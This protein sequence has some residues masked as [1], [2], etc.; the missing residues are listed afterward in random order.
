M[1]EVNHRTFDSWL[2]A[3]GRA[4]NQRYQRPIGGLHITGHH[5]QAVGAGTSNIALLQTQASVRRKICGSL[6][7]DEKILTWS[8]SA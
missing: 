8:F 2:E 5:W 6:G 1:D 7:F 3:Y 4:V